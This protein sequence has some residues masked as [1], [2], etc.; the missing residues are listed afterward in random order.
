KPTMYVFGTNWCWG[1]IVYHNLY[2]ADHKF[3]EEL[4]ALVNVRD[5]DFD[6]RHDLDQR[7]GIDKVPSSVIVRPDGS[8]I[9]QTGYYGKC[10][11]IHWIK[12]ALIPGAA[13]P[14]PEDPGTGSPGP[15]P[16]PPVVV[17]PAPAPAVAVKGDP[18]ARGEQGP[19]G[20]KGDKGDPG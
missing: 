13:P 6:S 16:S 5:V 7:Y 15:A 2:S 8:Y 10:R 1:C 14:P 20:D 3:R 17:S 9:K 11:L 4:G 19:K 18:G 12:S